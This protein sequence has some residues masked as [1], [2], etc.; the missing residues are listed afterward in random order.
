VTGIRI[1]ADAMHAPVAKWMAGILPQGEIWTWHFVA[2]ITLLFCASAYAVYMWRAGLASRNDLNKTRV[3]TM[4]A[5]SKLKWGAVN[6][7]L[8]WFLYAL[9]VFMA[10]TG[11]MLYLGHG[12]WWVYV[13]STAAFVALTY[14]LVHVVTHYL[15]GGWWQI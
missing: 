14:I 15:Y 6:V 1:A 13:H 3:L 10:V 9:V 2:G 12:G 11:I 8:H 7:A 5:P 4:H